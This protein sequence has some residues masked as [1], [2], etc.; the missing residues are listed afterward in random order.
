MEEDKTQTRQSRG[1]RS[2]AQDEIEED[3]YGEEAAED[4]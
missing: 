2:K 1:E 4:E 3:N